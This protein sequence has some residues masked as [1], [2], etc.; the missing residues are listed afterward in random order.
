MTSVKRDDQVQ[1]VLQGL[2]F[3]VPQE[4]TSRLRSI[5]QLRLK[6]LRSEDETRESA[7]RPGKDGGL[8]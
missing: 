4:F 8:G 2:N 6:D 1:S 7:L 5:I 3:S